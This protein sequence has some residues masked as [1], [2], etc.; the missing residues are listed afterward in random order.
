[1]H[2]QEE[3]ILQRK[4][5]VP[6]INTT[7]PLPILSKKPGISIASITRG[8]RYVFFVGVNLC[9]STGD[10]KFTA[11]NADQRDAKVSASTDGRKAGVKIAKE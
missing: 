3:R 7:T 9:A 6:I 2:H 11:S 4:S 5:A 8:E 10:K 1:V